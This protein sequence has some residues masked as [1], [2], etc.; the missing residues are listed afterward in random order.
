MNTFSLGEA[1]PMN[2]LDRARIEPMVNALTALQRP[3]LISHVKPDGDALGA[4]L[5]LASLLQDRGAAP[6]ALIY[7]P[8]PP[9]FSLFAESG[10]LKQLEQ[11]VPLEALDEHDGVVLLDTCALGQLSPLALWL[12][13]TALP[14]YAIDHHVTRDPIPEVGLFDESASATCLMLFELARAMDWPLADIAR[15][16]LFMGIATDTGW[17]KH[18]N[19]D[20]RTYHAAGALSELGA[21]PNRLFQSLWF[22]DSEARIRLLSATLATLELYADDRLA[23]LTIS[24]GTLR[25]VGATPSDTEEF[26]NEPLRIGSVVVSMLIVAQDDTDEVKIG[27]RSKAPVHDGVPDIDVAAHAQRF[28]GGG[29]RRA[30]GA[31]LRGK[32]IEVRRQVIDHF[33]GLLT[34]DD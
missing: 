12:A 28:G 25:R 19:T 2:T 9:R 33:E 21:N 32:F 14:K 23:V 26:V 20:A 22:S 15:D 1:S 6:T 17:F 10:M 29:H 13:E 31:R 34:P 30:A 27:L 7:E 16:A 4:L 8:L 18:A 11:D 24:P 3:L 5:G